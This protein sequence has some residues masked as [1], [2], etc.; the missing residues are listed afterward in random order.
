MT[1]RR[2]TLRNTHGQTMT[3][4]ALVLVLM[5]MV[6]MAVLPLF[7]TS[8]LHLWTSFANSFGGAG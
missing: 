1:Y 5:V 3:E 4:Y 2:Q 8:V 7:G 6:I